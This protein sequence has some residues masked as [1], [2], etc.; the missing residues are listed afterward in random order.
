MGEALLAATKLLTRSK[1]SPGSFLGSRKTAERKFFPRMDIL[2]QY[3]SLMR[4]FDP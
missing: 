2:N 4:S 3:E 1:T